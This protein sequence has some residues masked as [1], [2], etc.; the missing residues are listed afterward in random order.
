MSEDGFEAAEDN[1]H[2][3]FEDNRK[4]ALFFFMWRQ[5]GTVSHG[6]IIEIHP[7]KLI[8][9]PFHKVKKPKFRGPQFKEWY[10]SGEWKNDAKTYDPNKIESIRF[11]TEDRDRNQ[12]TDPYNV[13]VMDYGQ[14]H[15]EL[16]YIE[17]LN[18]FSHPVGHSSRS[19]DYTL[20]LQKILVETIKKRF[21]QKDDED[22]E[23]TVTFDGVSE[24]ESAK[25]RTEAQKRADQLSEKKQA[26]KTSTSD[27]PF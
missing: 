6:R 23:F 10:H 18:F 1:G 20:R 15:I 8:I 7:D 4:T 13:M 22:T 17:A 9:S 24:E 14:K 2:I 12:G 27:N 16:N 21:A 19:Q 25:I 26:P 11:I 5:S 3:F